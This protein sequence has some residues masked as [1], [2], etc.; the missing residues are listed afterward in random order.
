MRNA[1]FLQL[2]RVLVANCG[3]VVCF[4]AV[5]ALVGRRV[6]KRHH[7]QCSTQSAP[8]TIDELQPWTKLEADSV[9]LLLCHR[10]APAIDELDSIY[11]RLR[12]GLRYSIRMLEDNISAKLGF[13]HTI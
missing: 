5:E 3:I 7:G 13:N 10:R 11:S 4:V 1:L 12:L 9:R 8:L 2:A 6:K